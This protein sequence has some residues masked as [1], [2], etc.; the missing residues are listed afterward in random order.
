MRLLS[1]SG[2]FLF[3]LVVNLNVFVFVAPFGELLMVELL[4]EFGLEVWDFLFLGSSLVNHLLGTWGGS[5]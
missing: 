4:F 1:E 5:G 3:D 2:K